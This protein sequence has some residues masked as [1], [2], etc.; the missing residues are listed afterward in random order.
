MPLAGFCSLLV[1][2]LGGLEIADVLAF[3]GLVDRSKVII[4]ASERLDKA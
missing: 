1:L 2:H 4:A 3:G